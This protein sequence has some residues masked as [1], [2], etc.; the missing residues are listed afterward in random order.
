MR[1]MN[2]NLA[3][4]TTLAIAA[5]A[6]SGCTSGTDGGLDDNTIVAEGSSTVRPLAEVWAEQVLALETPLDVSVAGGGSTHGATAFCN[7]LTDVGH[8]SRDLRDSDREKCTASGRS[9]VQWK[10]AL[11]ALSVV[12]QQNDANAMIED[13]TIEELRD[14]F[15]AT[16]SATWDQV[17]EGF[18]AEEIVLCYPDD[19]SGTFGYFQE[20]VMETDDGV[21]EFKT[22]SPHQQSAED[23]VL[24]D[25]L[26]GD[27]YAIGFFGFSYYDGA[28]NTLRAIAIE[29]GDGEFVK[30]EIATAVDGS[31]EPLSRYLYMLTEQA[32]KDAV[33]VYLQYILDEGQDPAIMESA[34]FISLDPQTLGAMRT[35][36]ENLG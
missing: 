9:L 11:D 7:G 8:M 34:G 20:E 21:E 31:Y 6:L 17:R 18:P 15:S 35:Q 10:I 33:K 30:P 14:I 32:P 12:V 36:Y 4:L 28:R 27:E 3:I 19:A 22:G 29:N 25:C 5:V 13:L 16:G 26:K 24:V 1:T 2:T 23:E